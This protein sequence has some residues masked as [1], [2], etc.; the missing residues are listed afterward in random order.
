M[1]REHLFEHFSS[2]TRNFVFASDS[3]PGSRFSGK[4]LQQR[5]LRKLLD[6]VHSMACKAWRN[7]SR[8]MTGGFDRDDFIQEAMIVFAECCSSYDGKRSFENYVRFMVSKRMQDAGRRLQRSNPAL[9]RERRRLCSEV[10]RTRAE[11]GGLKALAA[12]SG[13]SVSDLEEIAAA[14]VGGRVLVAEQPDQPAAESPADTPTPEEEVEKSVMER[15][16]ADCIDRLG[17]REK[18]IFYLHEFDE[19]SLREIFELIGYE[20]S[21]ATFK[22]WYNA[23]IFTRV[24][25]CVKGQTER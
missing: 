3:D 10:K 21:L 12:A 20:R 22:R 2:I 1:D 5:Q 19:L 9:D 13:R 7:S 16:L 24:K 15:I 23:E 14:G 4:T 17:E 8:E 6:D 11:P 25:E 18:R